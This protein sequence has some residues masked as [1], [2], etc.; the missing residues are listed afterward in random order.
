[1]PRIARIVSVGYPH[2]ITQRGNN[3]ED[4]FINDADYMHYL[5]W[6]EE[7]ISKY[8]VSILAYCLM[9]N[10]VHFIAVPMA[11][12][13]FAKTFKVC[14]MLYSQYFNRKQ[15]RIGHLWQGRF[16]SCVLNEKHLYAAIRYVET[17]PIRAK[18]VKK[19]EDWRWSS[20]RV[21]LGIEKS[22]LSLGNINDFIDMN[23]WES[24]LELDQEEMVEEIR[25]NTL[26]GRPLV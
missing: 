4:I 5:K 17:N 12:Y 3:K 21:H 23:N 18:L 2:H 22:V 11:Y 1:M 15:V 7:C 20:A 14:H 25:A 26:T 13:S 16:H 8:K 10:H 9:P 6:L 24:Y 19:A